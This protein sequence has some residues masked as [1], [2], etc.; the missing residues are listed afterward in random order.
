MEMEM[1]MM[2]I[3]K[4]KGKREKS[5]VEVGRKEPQH[6]TPRPRP[7]QDQIRPEMK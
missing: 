6:I 3:N 4:L 7:R 2:M 5:C 1:E